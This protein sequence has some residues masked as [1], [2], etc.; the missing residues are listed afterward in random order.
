MWNRLLLSLSL[1]ATLLS[2]AFFATT[3]TSSQADENQDDSLVALAWANYTPTA[4]NNE[5]WYLDYLRRREIR[6]RDGSRER[7][8]EFIETMSPKVRAQQESLNAGMRNPAANLPRLRAEATELRDEFW[9][10]LQALL[11]EDDLTQLKKDYIRNDLIDCLTND[12]AFMQ[13][14][15][16]SAERG[17]EI[18]RAFLTAA[19]LETVAQSDRLPNDYI[20]DSLTQAE[21]ESLRELGVLNR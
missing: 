3:L 20:L 14:A 6:D 11:S 13:L 9:S 5:S 4:F 12:A 15:G 17:E 10:L 1:F 7:I 19:E 16:I 21:L 18:R 2:F 8:L